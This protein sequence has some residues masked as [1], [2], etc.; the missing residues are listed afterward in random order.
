MHFPLQLGIIPHQKIEYTHLSPNHRPYMEKK[1]IYN[2]FQTNFTKN[3]FC[4]A[5]LELHKRVLF[6]KVWWNQIS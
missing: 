3:F 6:Q 5:P 1:G 2:S 4:C